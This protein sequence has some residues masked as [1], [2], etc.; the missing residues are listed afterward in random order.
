[1]TMIS[2]WDYAAQRVSNKS[3]ATRIKHSP[4]LH[5]FRS[6]LSGKGSAM[7][8]GTAVGTMLLRLGIS[9]IP[10]PSIATS[11]INVAQQAVEKKL[12][13]HLHQKSLTGATTEEEKVKFT[14]KELS[15]EELDRYRWK[16]KE[17][18]E[19]LNQK[20]ASIDGQYGTKQGEGKPCDAWLDLAEALAQ[21]ER[22]YNILSLSAG[23][24]KTAMDE[25]LK[26]AND[27]ATVINN[28]K[29]NV[30]GKFQTAIDAETT[31]ADKKE[32]AAKGSG[33][34]FMNGRHANCSSY[35][36]WNEV[37]ATENAQWTAVKTKLAMVAKTVA[38][39]IGVEM[40]LATSADPYSMPKAQPQASSATP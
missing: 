33:D 14:L 7:S 25:A 19:Q 18:I 10:I 13:S 1:M 9:A 23:G 15:V 11:L 12:R 17:A 24:L 2:I 8:K 6:A 4:K 28:F 3:V 32:N 37:A 30:G 31:E 16:L 22:R 34:T 38:D 29:K 36:H 35:C 27:Q 39:P 20:A 21:A 26:W 5:A 40:F